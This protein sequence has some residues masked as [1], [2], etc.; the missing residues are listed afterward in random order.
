MIIIDAPQG[1]D[2]WL[3]ARVGK[4]TASRCKDARD[5]LKPAKGE[6]VGKPSSK[7]IQYA[8]QVAVERIAGRPLDKMFQSWQMR[9]GQTEEPHAR[10]AYDVETG[11]V[12]R[13]VGAITTDDG[14]FLYS[15][16]GLIGDDGLLEIKTLLSAE[17]IL[18]VIG[19][20]D[21]SE[22]MDQ[23]LDG[24]WL[25]GRKWI[26]LCLWAPALA[27]IGRELTIH[28]ITRDENAIEALEADLLAFAALVR[29]NEELLR[30]QAFVP[31]AELEAL[32]A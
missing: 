16:D 1:S 31:D 14:L 12:V 13:E 6:T 32:A 26:D 18:R 21:L 30:R 24:L 19:G 2:E 9:E 5:R 8:A 7:C 3:Q 10:N 20:G 29:K 27:P 4:I 17:V 11:N 25:T 28:R 23:C 22:Y 15:P